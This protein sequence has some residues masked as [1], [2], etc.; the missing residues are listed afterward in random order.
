MTQPDEAAAA[1]KY[2]F[3]EI[4]HQRD[5]HRQFD[6]KATGS[7]AVVGLMIVVAS[8]VLPRLDGFALGLA[9]VGLVLVVAAGFVFGLVL[10]PRAVSPTARTTTVIKET[11]LNRVSDPQRML[12]G[13]VQKLATLEEDTKT[14]HE[15]V[16]AGLW[17]LGVALFFAALAAVA[18]AGTNA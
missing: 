9:W 10:M 8:T 16:R 15:F 6:S 18:V 7:F 4:T 3:D 11:A 2:L 14:K 13:H 5:L 12:W 17:L 1:T